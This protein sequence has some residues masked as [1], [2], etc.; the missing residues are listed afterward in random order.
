MFLNF[1][2]H[3]HKIIHQNNAS[4]RMF[5]P[6]CSPEL[7]YLIQ[8]KACAHIFHTSCIVDWLANHS[9]T[10]PV[11]R[12]ELP[13]DDPQYEQGRIERM[14]YRKP[15]FAMHELQRLKISDLLTLN[16]RRRLPVSAGVLEKGDL[17]QMLIDTNLVDVIPSPEPVEYQLEVLKH[18]KIGE[19]KRT[20]AEAGV[21]FRREDVL[22]KSDMITVFENSGRLILTFDESDTSPDIMYSNNHEA[23]TH[24][25]STRD[26]EKNRIIVETVSE[27]LLEPATD[28]EKLVEPAIEMFPNQNEEVDSASVDPTIP[29][30]QQRLS[31]STDSH[32]NNVEPDQTSEL[33]TQNPMHSDTLSQHH[34]AGIESTA[35]DVDIPDFDENMTLFNAV[36]G[37]DTQ[38]VAQGLEQM[39]DH[40]EHVSTRTA[41]R[42]FQH[43]TVNN[44]QTLGRDLLIDLSHCLD[45]EEMIDTFINTGINGNVDPSTLL[46]R[47]FSTWSVSQL[48]V[49]ASESKINLSEC[50]TK[51]EMIERIVY[52]GN[53]ERPYLRDYLRSLCPLTTKNLADLRAIARELR[54]N[55]SDCLEKDEIIQRLITR[56]QQ[57]IGSN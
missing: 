26:L 35:I 32:E 8:N 55:I 28:D 44:L 52:A 37:S 17:I 29:N 13:T 34:A 1:D 38:S 42:T 2:L 30:S 12:Y 49:V 48:R 47:M 43:Y 18:M 36:N 3:T 25:S 16:N 31:L 20:M 22:M 46:P 5:S 27:D 14:Q 23:T 11:C 39:D 21:F 6:H 7:L 9:C 51:R 33:N 56:N 45:R 4:H 50:T 53:V 41:K 15:R 54:I 40:N 24:S 57:Q 10:C 19:L